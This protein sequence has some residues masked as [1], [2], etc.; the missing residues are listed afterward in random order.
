MVANA[1]TRFTVAFG[2]AVASAPVS[3]ETL[4]EAMAAAYRYNPVLETG[5]SGV[6]AVDENVSIAHSGFRPVVSATGDLTWEK[7]TTNGAPPGGVVVGPGGN[8]TTGGIN[9]QAGY[10][11]SI[12]QPIF[13]GFQTVNQVRAAEANVRGA[14]EL[15]RDTERNV[16]LQVANAYVSV[17]TAQEILK[18]Q[19]QN[20]G[21]LQDEVRVSKQ[22][23]E[24]TELTSTDLAQAELRRAGALSSVAATRAELAAARASYL[25]VVGHEPINLRSPGVP[26]L[27]KSLGDAQA[28][29]ASENP[30]IISALYDEQAARYIIDQIRGQLLPSVSVE[31]SYDEE[32]NS[33]GVENQQNL[34]VAG[35]LTVPI[36]EG[37]QVH[38]AV[39][40]AKQVH[41]GRLQTIEA[42]RSLVQRSVTTAWAQF[43]AS[44]TRVNLGQEQVRVSRVALEGVRK[45]EGI[46]QRTLLDVLNAEQDIVNSRVELLVAQRDYTITAFQV[47]GELGRLSAEQL[48]LQTLVYDPTVHYE[49]VRRQWFGIDITYS[50]GTREHMDTAPR[51]E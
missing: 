6:R 13:N 51:P 28:I 26:A 49:E 31:G 34:L 8:V 12:S 25:G 1:L 23:V 14:R 44:R 22:R 2:F 32:F 27:P 47:L 21:R 43:D 3:A 40:Q 7:I 29:A 46:G 48:S 4:A 19:E 33:S 17:L 35:R 41:V 11:V 37:G 45:E 5:R 10:G 24:L 39:R 36:Y 30:L 16:L 42:V 20:L 9:R 18:A 15:L 50:D 38:A